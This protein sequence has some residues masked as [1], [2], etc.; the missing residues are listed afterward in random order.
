MGLAL[1]L[2]VMRE[3]QGTDLPSTLKN[4]KKKKKRNKMYEIVFL[5]IG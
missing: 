2:L 1:S 4:Q 3:L 5:E